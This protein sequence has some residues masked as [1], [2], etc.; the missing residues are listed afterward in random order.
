M[1]DTGG[2]VV[3][4]LPANAGDTRDAGS[5]PGSGSTKTLLA[6]DLVHFVHKGQ[7]CLLFQVSLGFLLYFPWIYE[8]FNK[9]FANFTTHE[10][11]SEDRKS[12]V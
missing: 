3:K 1:G 9:S 10:C 11:L 6:F 7:V 5:I 4:N 2:T 12:V 8:S